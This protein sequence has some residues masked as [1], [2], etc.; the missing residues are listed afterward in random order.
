MPPKRGE[1]WLPQDNE[2]LA[3]SWRKISEDVIRSTGQKKEEFWC[4]VAKDYN[5][6]AS[7][8][9]WDSTSVMYRWG[10]IQ[11]STLKFTAIYNWLE[12]NQPSGLVMADLLPDAKKAYYEQD[13]KQLIFEPAWQ[14]VKN[15][16]KWIT[17]DS[18]DTQDLSQALPSGATP[19][20][21]TPT[22]AA[23]C[24]EDGNSTPGNHQTSWN[25][26]PGVHTTKR[27]MKQD[28]FHSK[29]IKTLAKRSRN[30]RERTIAMNQ[31]N[32]I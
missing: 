22:N 13:G 9:E 27:L 16:P 20:A 30:Y 1:N 12:K 18:G 6:F 10:D 7:G 11:K 3:K 19:D 29:K 4:R 2:Q 15:L 32:K 21:H 14:I 5:N 8:V 31:T 28:E 23:N 17:T 25:R 26:P 24:A